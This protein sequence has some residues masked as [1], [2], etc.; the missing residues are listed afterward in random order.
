MNKDNYRDYVSDAYRYYA[1][2]GKPD[3]NELR[4]LR[5][6]QAQSYR[7]GIA[8]LEAVAR[9]LERLELEQDAQ[10]W[11]RCL[12]IVYF[13]DPRHAPNR[14]TLTDRVRFAAM[15]LCISESTVYRMMRRLRMLLAMERGLR[16][17]ERELQ[18]MN[19]RIR[20]TPRPECGMWY[21]TQCAPEA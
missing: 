9:V 19:T 11:K 3:Q 6:S 7:G 20:V 8:D 5:S 2:C 1:L 21:G 14:G 18:S 4:A 17:D 15:E 13:S 10:I 12:D 16:V